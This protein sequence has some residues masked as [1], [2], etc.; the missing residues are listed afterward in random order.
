MRRARG[1]LISEECRTRATVPL[2]HH[3]G[4]A[5]DELEPRVLRVLL[6][7]ALAVA[8]VAAA[9]F[10]ALSVL[11]FLL[12][13]PLWWL[14]IPAA[15]GTSILLLGVLVWVVVRSKLRAWRRHIARAHEVEQAVF[16][17]A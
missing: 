2:F 15:V 12:D 17:D 8:L 1:T 10:Y 3:V 9:P 13:K 6:K 11:F 4:T 7:V 14:A 5:W 16:N